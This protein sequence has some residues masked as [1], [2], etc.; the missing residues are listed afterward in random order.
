MGSFGTIL[1]ACTLWTFSTVS[2][3]SVPESRFHFNP[4]LLS[5]TFPKC[6]LQH[7]KTVALD[8]FVGWEAPVER[9][10]LPSGAWGG[11][12]V[13]PVQTTG[14]TSAAKISFFS[15]RC[16]V[17]PRPARLRNTSLRCIHR[18]R[19]SGELDKPDYSKPRI[20]ASIDQ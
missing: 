16:F 14:L 8:I 12:K 20:E 1:G 17:I 6:R 13:T 3:P 15:H 11:L 7:L 9:L 5:P 2:P 18:R 19:Q 10:G 4:L